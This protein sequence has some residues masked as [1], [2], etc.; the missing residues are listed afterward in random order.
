[1]HVECNVLHAGDFQQM[2]KRKTGRDD[3]VIRALNK[4]HVI[5]NL[6]TASSLRSVFGSVEIYRAFCMGPLDELRISYQVD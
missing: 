1:M 3:W 2:I 5:I 4:A 6:P